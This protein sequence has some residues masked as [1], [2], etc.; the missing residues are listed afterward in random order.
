VPYFAAVF[1]R[2]EAGWVGVDA[3]RLVELGERALPGDALGIVAEVAGF[4]DEFDR[5][6]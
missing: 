6:R 1:G 2:T 5:L 3:D 4:A